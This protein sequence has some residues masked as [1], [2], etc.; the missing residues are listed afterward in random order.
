MQWSRPCVNELK[1]VCFTDIEPRFVGGG[2]GYDHMQAEL[3]MADEYPQAY[4]SMGRGYTD[5]C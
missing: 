4:D 1:C 5:A 2:Y 3:D